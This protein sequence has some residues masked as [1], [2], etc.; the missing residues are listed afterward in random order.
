YRYYDP[1]TGRFISRDPIG[2]L[3]GMNV[4]AYA[5]NPVEWVDPLGLKKGSCKLDKSLAGKKGDRMQAQHLIPQAVWDKKEGFFNEIGLGGKWRDHRSNG[6]LMPDNEKD[7]Y[8]LGRKYFH[9]GSHQN[10]SDAV[11]REVERLEFDYSSGRLSAA[12]ARMEVG[13]IQSERRAE[14][15]TAL[16]SGKCPERLG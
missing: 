6:V 14:M 3:G 2:L 15:L 13:R 1:D 9:N 16:P 4:H 8:A 11:E 12:D 10:Y 7:A 5:P